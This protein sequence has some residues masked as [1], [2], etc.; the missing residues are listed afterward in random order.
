MFDRE[1]L[2]GKY[3]RVLDKGFIS[4]VDVMGDDS[5]IVQAA[6][7]S[8]GQGTKAVSDDRNLIRYL[9]RNKHTTPIEMVT[10]KFHI[11]MPLHCHRQFIRHRMS[12]T[13]E[14]SA[15]YSEVPEVYYDDYK[16]NVQSKNN[17]QGRAEGTVEREQEYKEEVLACEKL[18][19]ELYQDMIKDGVAREVARMHLPLNSYTYFYWKID[20][21]NL[22]HF[23]RLR[24]DSHA[25]YEIRQFANTLAGMVKVCCPVAFEAWYDYSFA[26]SNFTRLDKELLQYLFK[27]VL[28]PEINML[29]M[30]NTMCTIK[31][32]EF[33][34]SIGVSDREL[35]EFWAKLEVPEPQDFDLDETKL[36]VPEVQ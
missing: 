10:L 19:F 28:G 32:K 18:A 27:R 4:L 9:L 24:C 15:R 17:K 2:K 35:A 14:Y 8:Y 29:V 21:H 11:S 30:K 13:N 25:Q 34:K 5:S 36:F 7:V 16:L 26:A 12:S 1:S 20:L 23:L 22:F 3:F 6:R 33:A 31:F